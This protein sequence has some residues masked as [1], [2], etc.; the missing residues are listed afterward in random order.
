MTATECVEQF[1]QAWNDMDF[2]RIVALLHE[3]IVY[4][5]IPMPV[6]TGKDE[7]TAYLGKSWKLFES[8]DWQLLNIAASGNTVLTERVDDFIINGSPI[9]LPVMGTFEISDNRIIAWRDYFDLLPY[10]EQ[11]KA[12][13]ENE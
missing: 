10:R 2:A 6:L 4:H 11:V 13:Q 8:I 1:I 7:V 5:N 12:A 3:D 9:S